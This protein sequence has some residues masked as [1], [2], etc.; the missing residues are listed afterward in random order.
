MSVVVRQ[1]GAGNGK[2]YELIRSI[3]AGDADAIV[4]TKP[5]T[6]KDMLYAEI[7]GA[8]TTAHARSKNRA[9]IVGFRGADGVPR[10]AIFATVD[11]FM[12]AIGDPARGGRAFDSAVRSVDDEQLARS[13]PCDEDGAWL[14]FKGERVRVDRSVVL[15]DEAQDLGLEYVRAL[16]AYARHTESRVVLI[17]DKLQSIQHEENAFTELRT[18]STCSL[19]SASA[20]SIDYEFEPARNVCRRFGPRIASFVNR[21]IFHDE[22]NARW[23][24]GLA[25]ITTLDAAPSE[26]TV[27]VTKVPSAGRGIAEKTVER[28]MDALSAEVAMH[29]ALRPNDVLVV[30]PFVRNYA[31]MEALEMRLSEFWAERGVADAAYLHVSEPGHPVN[32]EHSRDATRLVSIH[33]S[34]GD[35][36][37]VVFVVGLTEAALSRFSDTEVPSESLIYLSLLHVALTRAVRSMHVFLH[38]LD[39]DVTRRFVRAGV[40][41]DDWITRPAAAWP[42]C[43]TLLRDTINSSTVSA[44]LIQ[45][46]LAS[47]IALAPPTEFIGGPSGATGTNGTVGPNGATGTSGANGAVSDAV[48]HYIEYSCMVVGAI[49]HVV[50]TCRTRGGIS[51]LFCSAQSRIRAAVCVDMTPREYATKYIFGKPRADRREAARTERREEGRREADRREADKTERTDRREADRREADRTERTDRREGASTDRPGRREDERADRPVVPIVHGPR[52]ARLRELVERVKTLDRPVTPLDMCVTLYILGH[53]YPNMIDR[54]RGMYRPFSMYRVIG[55]FDR[56]RARTDA[57]WGQ[58]SARLAR[59]ECL[60]RAAVEFAGD[61]AWLIDYCKPYRLSPVDEFELTAQHGVL[62]RFDRADGVAYVV[63]LVCRF[64]ADPYAHSIEALVDAITNE[65]KEGK[66]SA[67]LVIALDCAAPFVVRPPSDQRAILEYTRLAMRAHYARLNAEIARGI[68]KK[69]IPLYAER[70]IARGATDPAS[71]DRDLDAAIEA[72]VN[73]I[74]VRSTTVFVTDVADYVPDETYESE[75]VA[76]VFAPY[77]GPVLSRAHARACGERAPILAFGGSMSKD[78]VDEP[79]AHAANAAR[80]ALDA[81]CVAPRAEVPLSVQHHDNRTLIGRAD[82]IDSRGVAVEFKLRVGPTA[83]RQISCY[84]AMIMIMGGHASGNAIATGYVVGLHDGEVHR[85]VVRD[86]VPIIA[87]CF[88]F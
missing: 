88:R 45:S 46:T 80:A 74:F 49:M 68:V 56:A 5:H 18:G 52:A 14:T 69:R 16:E 32:L 79:T 61:T 84:L 66:D 41:A 1:Q 77:T 17:G 30:A 72:Y 53:T 27:T 12:F 26:G 6:N 10:R 3:L 40:V 55:W 54:T 38:D 70:A 48:H 8:A 64:H 57:E 39:D 9:W 29:P 35:G 15:V 44:M 23:T 62:F 50:D 20:A 83:L 42:A 21:L 47:I 58:H 86:P 4:L 71:L 60:M 73:E 19:R 33:A 7:M 67:C 34:K 25:P 87:A 65:R 59:L 31:A 75:P 37:R 78:V 36:R 63:H 13:V 82:V 22:A 24:A 51:G 2:S 11:S 43:P 76:P 81:F 28:V 85:V